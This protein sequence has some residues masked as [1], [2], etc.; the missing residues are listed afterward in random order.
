[1]DKDLQVLEGIGPQIKQKKSKV[2][3]ANAES[4]RVIGEMKLPTQIDNNVRIILA[5]VVSDIKRRLVL[6]VD[7]WRLFGK[8]PDLAKK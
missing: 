3:L 2:H 4:N 5:L 1:M 7:A 6:R 8:V